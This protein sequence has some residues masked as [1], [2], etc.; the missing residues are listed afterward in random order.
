M[1]QDSLGCRQE[2]LGAL[3]PV[4][5]NGTAGLK[6]ADLKRRTKPVEE[7]FFQGVFHYLSPSAAYQSLNNL[8]NT[9][10]PLSGAR[11]LVCDNLICLL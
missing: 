1:G 3:T 5:K 9:F 11:K 6:Q 4:Q 2:E 8:Q 7:F 10:C